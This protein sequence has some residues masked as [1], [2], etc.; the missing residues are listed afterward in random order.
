MRAAGRPD[1]PLLKQVPK[2]LDSDFNHVASCV[3]L[4]AQPAGDELFVFLLFFSLLVSLFWRTMSSLMSPF[5]WSSFECLVC[6]QT[7]F[8]PFIPEAS[9]KTTFSNRT[10]PWKGPSG[11]SSALHPCCFCTDTIE[12]TSLQ[13]LT[14]VVHPVQLLE[15]QQHD[16]RHP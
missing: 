1:T 15:H 13:H 8:F 4:L 14:T 6:L 11:L 7:F 9:T 10:C 16:A 3:Q 5:W 2:A 12:H